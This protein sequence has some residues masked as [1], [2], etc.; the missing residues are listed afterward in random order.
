MLFV[1]NKSNLFGPV[2]I[3][4]RIT[5]I[6]THGVM[7]RKLEVSFFW[8]PVIIEGVYGIEQGHSSD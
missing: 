6:M 1:D 5:M 3:D 7:L 2:V 8:S 4:L